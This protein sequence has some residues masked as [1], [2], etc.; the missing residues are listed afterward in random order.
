MPWW[1]SFACGSLNV[2]RFFQRHVSP[3]RLAPHTASQTS[4]TPRCTDV[5]AR[6]GFGTTGQKNDAIH[7]VVDDTISAIDAAIS[8]HVHPDLF[9][10]ALGERREAVALH[11]AALRF[12]AFNAA[13]R[14][15]PPA[16]T[17]ATSLGVD[18]RSCSV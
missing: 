6:P 18:V 12:R 10:I 3:L 9:E 14:F 13:R 5:P 17:R 15:L 7:D 16:F 11:R 1:I 4:G 2:D 8:G